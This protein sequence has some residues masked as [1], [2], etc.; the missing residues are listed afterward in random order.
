[1]PGKFFQE[2]VA[3]HASSTHAGRHN[4]A[5]MATNTFKCRTG[6]IDNL[7]VVTWHQLEAA[8]C[9]A[10]LH[11][12]FLYRC[13][14][15]FAVSSSKGLLSGVVMTLEFGET[16]LCLYRIRAFG[17][18]LFLIFFYFF[19]RSCRHHL[20][21][22]RHVLGR[23]KIAHQNISQSI[24]FGSIC[25]GFKNVLNGARKSGQRRKNVTDTFFN[26]FGNRDLAFTGQ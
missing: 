2:G 24:F 21:G 4:I 3:R 13:G 6:K 5:F 23:I 22:R 8:K 9:F 11:Q 14:S 1:M 7:I 17:T 12:L 10:Q 20:R 16:F 25:I 18:F 15:T 26:A 19:A